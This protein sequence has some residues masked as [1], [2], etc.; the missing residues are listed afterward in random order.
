MAS[1]SA[2]GTRRGDKMILRGTSGAML[3]CLGVPAC[4]FRPAAL[5]Q[6]G[7]VRAVRQGPSHHRHPRRPHR[8]TQDTTSIVAGAA[9]TAITPSLSELPPYSPLPAL[10]NCRRCPQYKKCCLAQ[11]PPHLDG[12][13][14]AKPL[15]FCSGIHSTPPHPIPPHTA[16][17]IHTPPHP[18]PTPS[19][20]HPI[21]TPPHPSPTPPLPTRALYEL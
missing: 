14:G 21:H 9:C 18:S 10:P 15:H 3:A 13:V 16:S 11:Q 6:R 2:F 5:L 20:P 7:H 12:T 4:V 1:R 8:S 19:I 17:A